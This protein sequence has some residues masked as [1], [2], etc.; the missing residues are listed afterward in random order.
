MHHNLA[1]SLVNCQPKSGGEKDDKLSFFQHRERASEYSNKVI[2]VKKGKTTTTTTTK[3]AKCVVLESNKKF[4]LSLKSEI[5][6][7]RRTNENYLGPNKHF[8]FYFK[9]RSQK[10]VSS[11]STAEEEEEEGGGGNEREKKKEKKEKKE[12]R[13]RSR[14][15]STFLIESLA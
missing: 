7:L 13:R 5:S 6:L 3:K 15:R 9:S 1:R 14:R 12:K 10:F 4:S 2:K 11:A 8:L